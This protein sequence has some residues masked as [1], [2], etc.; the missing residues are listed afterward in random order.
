MSTTLRVSLAAIAFLAALA[1]NSF[2][3]LPDIAGL[4]AQLRDLPPLHPDATAYALASCLIAFWML[5]FA[6]PAF[7]RFAGIT[8][9]SLSVMGMFVLPGVLAFLSV[10]VVG[11]A[12]A[13]AFAKWH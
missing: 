8:G 1:F 12:I 13:D 4:L 9:R 7:S 2:L 6:L 11:P 5:P 10:V 3:A